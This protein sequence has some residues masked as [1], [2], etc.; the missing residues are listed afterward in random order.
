MLSLQKGSWQASLFCLDRWLSKGIKPAKSNK[1][2]VL[3]HET[4][5][6][7]LIGLLLSAKTYLSAEHDDMKKGSMRQVAHS[8]LNSPS[9][10]GKIKLFFFFFFKKK[11]S[12]VRHLGHT[13]VRALRNS[14]TQNSLVLRGKGDKNHGTLNCD[15]H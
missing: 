2:S 14:R 6:G 12:F 1:T 15:R 9:L 5:S 13:E 4:V 3:G 11:R 10:L 8:I 7:K